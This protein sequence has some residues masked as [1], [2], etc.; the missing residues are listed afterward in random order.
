M[1]QQIPE[2]MQRVQGGYREASSQSGA[3]LP[4]CPGICWVRHQVLDM[5]TRVFQTPFW[6]L[7]IFSHVAFKLSLLNLSIPAP[8]IC[9]IFYTYHFFKLLPLVWPTC[10]GG[11]NPK[12]GKQIIL[13]IAFPNKSFSS[14]SKLTNLIIEFYLLKQ[15]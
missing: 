11:A 7:A 2:G 9:S 6:H 3:L 1:A 5:S 13:A 15:G 8:Q 10:Q 12:T 14:V 4:S